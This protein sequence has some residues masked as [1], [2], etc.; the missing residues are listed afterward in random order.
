MLN[1]LLTILFNSF[2]DFLLRVCKLIFESII[3]S[4]E[5][6]RFK[7]KD[8][9]GFDTDEKRRLLFEDFVRE[10]YKIEQETYNVYRKNLN[11]RFEEI[12]D[13]SAEF[14]PEMKTDMILSNE[15]R[16]IIIDTKFTEA[17]RP[18][19]H[20]DQRYRIKEGHLYQIYAYMKNTEV[21]ENQSLEGMLLYPKVSQDIDLQFRKDGNKISQGKI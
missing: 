7:F 21:S 17:L 3:P 6:G 1:D 13:N 11:W 16:K 15:N 10:F 8:P 18:D 19:Q 4:E 2:Y 20:N 5:P 14:V 12:T 9:V